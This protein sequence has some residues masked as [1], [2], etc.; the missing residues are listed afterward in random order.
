MLFCHIILNMLFTW[1]LSHLNAISKCFPFSLLFVQKWQVCTTSKSTNHRFFF[2]CCC[3]ILFVLT[4]FV[5]R[6]TLFSYKYIRILLLMNV[7]WW[8]FYFEIAATHCL[9]DEW[10]SFVK[11]FN[12]PI[13]VDGCAH[14]HTMM[15]K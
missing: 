10:N 6:L 14:T 11:Q 7:L 12:F 4:Q 13:V 3:W 15:K 2:S 5:Y 1:I 8:F 9:H